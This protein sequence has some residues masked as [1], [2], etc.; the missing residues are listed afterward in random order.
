MATGKARVGEIELWWEDFGER[1]DAT[2]TVLL[3]MGATAEATAWPPAFYEPLVAA[4]YHVVRFDNRDIGLSTWVDFATRPYT[5]A[6]MAADAVGLLDVLDI[7]AAHWIGA[8]MGG[9]IAQQAA[10]DHPERVLSLTSIMSSPAGPTSADPDLPPME[11][12]VQEAMARAASM[13]PVS[14]AV[15]LYRALSGSRFPF[16]E[17]AFRAFLVAG[18]GRGG[19]NPACAHAQAIEASPSRREALRGLQMP[20]LVLHGSE[21]PILPLAHGRA[22]AEAIPGARLVVAEG[23]GHE[24]PAPAMREY[25]DPIL[26][27][28][29]AT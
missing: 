4:G 19:F 5:V 11:A 10:I 9:M 17:E 6:D 25:L 28:L 29:R 13:D 18:A 21:D 12:K 1:S 7:P 27:L 22:T 15:E 8:S 14:A 24:L 16:D 23:I 26:E 3:V 20:A 2:A